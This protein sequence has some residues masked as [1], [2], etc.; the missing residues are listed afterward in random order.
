MSNRSRMIV[1]M[2][3]LAACGVALGQTVEVYGLA[4]QFVDSSKTSGATSGAPAD[5]PAQVGTA[6]Y[7]GAT[8]PQRLKTSSGTSNLGFRGSEELGGGVKAIW[9][10]ESA[11][12]IDGSPGP[13][14]SG[15][16]SYVGLAS[17]WGTISAGQW[18]TPYKVITLPI[19]AIRVGYQADYT[20]I[21]GNPGF[22]V[23]ATTTQPGRIG[24]KP[25]AAF[26]RRAGNTVQYWS[27]NVGGFTARLMYEANEGKTASSA[28][29]P[30]I[31]PQ[32]FSG[33]ITY[34]LGSLSLRYGYEQHDD[35]FGMSQ[36]G[37][38][39]GATLTNSGSKD[40]GNKFAAIWRFGSTR[41]AAI[42]ERLEY[43]NEDSTAGAVSSFKRNAYYVFGEQRFGNHALWA[44]YGKAEDGSCGRVGGASCSTSQLGADYISGGW[45]YTFSK[46]TQAIATYYRVNN[47]TS[48]TYATQ[49]TAGAAVAPGAETMGFG[50][51]LAHFF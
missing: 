17:P 48:G 43:R 13:G 36:L 45:V 15:R 21:M 22:G 10:M 50:V 37:G 41:L 5:R 23:P 7:T 32:L 27:P 40:R 26:D 39:A 42:A 46:R 28:T 44:A 38:S 11:F 24:A 34:D 35:F 30:A 3:G 31:N 20:P 4:F 29:A 9:Q 49:P 33:T 1:G 16:N 47:K 19:N 12:S 8:D 2:V 18:D 6:A 25:D 14:F 51:G